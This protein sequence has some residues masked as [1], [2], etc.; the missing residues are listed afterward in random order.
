MTPETLAAIHADANQ[1]ERPWTAAEFAALMGQSGIHLLGDARSFVLGR[2][3]LDEAEILTI[4]TA[5]AHRRQG[6][7]RSVL[8]AFHDLARAKGALAS[9]L[10]VAETNAPARALYAG[11]GY[12]QVGVRPGYYDHGPGSKVAAFVLRKP[13]LAACCRGGTANV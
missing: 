13:L 9:F 3:T 1:T 6:L 5:Q 8:T 12:E 7:A 10:E 2:V 4:A 11:L